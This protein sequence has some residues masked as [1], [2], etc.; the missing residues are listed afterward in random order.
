MAA[1]V[2]PAI[3]AG[4]A[5][6][7][8]L[9]TSAFNSREA[10]KNR[11][12][13]E[14]MSSTAHQREM[15]DLRAAGLSPVLSGKHGGASTPSGA[16]AQA[17]APDIMHSAMQAASTEAQIKDLNSAAALKDAQAGDILRTQLDRVRL[18][19]AQWRHEL[20]KAD[21]TDMEKLNLTQE[22]RNLE[23]QE[24]Q[25]EMDI[26]HSALDLSRSKADA[27]FYEGLGGDIERWIKLIPNLPSVNILRGG[28][29]R[30]T[31]VYHHN[32]ERR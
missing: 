23:K 22:L 13:Q 19:Q 9:I 17:T 12:F 25:L 27:K 32:M 3:I 30:R 1:W 11:D 15:L 29:H 8:G 26:S 21:K 16:T 28:R 14:K 10:E 4:G 2:A 31:D 18:M 24:K 5:I 6:A 7:Q 20:Q